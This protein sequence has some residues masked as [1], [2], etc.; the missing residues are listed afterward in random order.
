MLESGGASS[1]RSS[2]ARRRGPLAVRAQRLPL[3]VVGV[4]IFGAA[5]QSI[6]ACVT[7]RPR[8]TGYIEGQNATIE[9]HWSAIV[10][11]CDTYFR[12]Q[13]DSRVH[14]VQAHMIRVV[15]IS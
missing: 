1:S 6:A 10:K 4:V 11:G 5:D 8:R 2:A 12:L 15:T 9:Y 13:P 3:P 14:G 7:Q